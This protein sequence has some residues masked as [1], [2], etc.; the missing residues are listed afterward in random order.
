MAPSAY[1]IA[2]SIGFRGTEAEFLEAAKRHPNY[3]S[4]QK[5]NTMD[6]GQTELSR[7]ECACGRC[8]QRKDLLVNGNP[9]LDDT[10]PLA[11]LLREQ[12]AQ[13][14]DF[15]SFSPSIA[16]PLQV[17]EES[18][19]EKGK[20]V[21]AQSQLQHPS[22]EGFLEFLGQMLGGQ[23]I[24]D[25]E[26]ALANINPRGLGAPSEF[27]PEAQ[28]RAIRAGQEARGELPSFLT[29]P[30]FGVPGLTQD[31]VSRILSRLGARDVRLTTPKPVEFKLA[32]EVILAAKDE[33]LQNYITA[34]MIPAF[35]DQLANLMANYAGLELL[36]QQRRVIARLHKLM[37]YQTRPESIQPNAIDDVHELSIYKHYV[38]KLVVERKLTQ[39]DGIA[40]INNAING[41][42]SRTL[43]AHENERAQQA[44]PEPV[45]T[46]QEELEKSMLELSQVTA[47]MG[48]PEAIQRLRGIAIKFLGE[49]AKEAEINNLVGQLLDELSKLVLQ[50]QRSPSPQVQA[51]KASVFPT[52][53]ARRMMH[54]AHMQGDLGMYGHPLS[55]N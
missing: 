50:R 36:R 48:I 16:K 6:Y 3:V 53:D 29:Q 43:A 31:E 14:P 7:Q 37:S 35:F 5:G 39:N 12:A 30:E 15:R 45:L 22:Q 8:T 55:L 38:A 4:P 52:S 49:T 19:M 46:P 44:K 17:T 54:H 33:T 20:Q 41:M 18:L 34:K 26:N 25:L 47:N 23:S 21:M 9:V 1:D 11:K 27:S 2:R 24:A 42:N 28:H 10:H 51:A 40:R 13:L 32:D